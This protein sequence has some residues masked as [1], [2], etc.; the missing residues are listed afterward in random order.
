MKHVP[1]DEDAIEYEG[2]FKSRQNMGDGSAGANSPG[3]VLG[4]V[5][6]GVRGL[7]ELSKCS[8][9]S[10]QDG[11]VAEVGFVEGSVEDVAVTELDVAERHLLTKVDNCEAIAPVNG[12]CVDARGQVEVQCPRM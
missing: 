1:K 3:I 7:Q 5:F 6:R 9:P 12:I 4:T 11:G 10:S 2:G 8:R